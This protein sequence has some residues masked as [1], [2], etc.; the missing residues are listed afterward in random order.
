LY[1][2]DIQS[3]DLEDESFDDDF[4]EPNENRPAGSNLD[5]GSAGSAL[6]GVP[7]SRRERNLL[8]RFLTTKQLPLVSVVQQMT[9]CCTAVVTPCYCCSISTTLVR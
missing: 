9:L 8:R 3:F 1:S 4:G 5:K 6:I 7:H 2:V